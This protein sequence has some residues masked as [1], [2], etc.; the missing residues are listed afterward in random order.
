M[1]P[2]FF[3]SDQIVHQIPPVKLLNFHLG[4]ISDSTSSSPNRIACASFKPL[5][6]L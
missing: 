1:P 3:F 5:D 2:H 4:G 6:H